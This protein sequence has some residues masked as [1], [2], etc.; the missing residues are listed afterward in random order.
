MKQILSCL[1]AI[2]LILFLIPRESP[3]QPP[4]RC[5][6][7]IVVDGP[8]ERNVALA[9]MLKN[10]ILEVLGKDAAV[11]FP[12]R[13]F[14]VG[15]WTID[16]VRR[17]D[18]RLLAD[19]DIDLVLGMGLIT[20]QDLATRGPLKKPVIAPIVIDPERQHIPMKNGT[21]GVNNLNY[22][23][24]PTTFVRD[25]ELYREIIPIRKLVNISSKPY[26]DVM[27]APNISLAEL[28]KRLHL[29]ITE[30]PLG[31]SADEVLRSLPRD[32]DAVFLEP[33]L[34][35]PP[36]EFEKLVRGFIERRL[37]SFAAFG[38]EEV[39]SRHHGVSQSGHS[40]DAGPTDRH[41]DAEDSR[42]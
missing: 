36:A 3:A 28:G 38:E 2:T 6:I 21:S 30:I 9:E 11:E 41:H 14:L 13:A 16:S 19:P 10:G 42:R 34:H 5:R 40:A 18:D 35:L 1:A 20:S 4:K 12:S 33:S 32:A 8:W 15:N 22:L 37:P 17:L 29:E 39:A 25:I 26:D 24:Y 7:G 27:P 23:V 31:F